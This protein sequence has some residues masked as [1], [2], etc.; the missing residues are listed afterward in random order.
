MLLCTRLHRSRLEAFMFD[1]LHK[2][3]GRLNT[4]LGSPGDRSF[5]SV[6]FTEFCR[7][8]KSELR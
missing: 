6:I 4:L 8:L 5:L 3:N 7:I 1:Q 2:I